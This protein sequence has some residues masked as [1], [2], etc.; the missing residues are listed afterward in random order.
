MLKSHK[1]MLKLIDCVCLIYILKIEN[2]VNKLIMFSHT[3]RTLY[4]KKQG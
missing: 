1:I 4:S 3:N 2:T